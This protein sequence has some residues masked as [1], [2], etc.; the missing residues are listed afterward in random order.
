MSLEAI[1]LQND[2]DSLSNVSWYTDATC[3]FQN[4]KDKEEKWR[5]R[6]EGNGSFANS[7]IS[8]EYL[9]TIQF[10]FETTSYILGIADT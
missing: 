4:R 1:T 7:F 2:A 6:E 8:L 10:S 9:L 5:I 3:K